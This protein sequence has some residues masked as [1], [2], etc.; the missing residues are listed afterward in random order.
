MLQS[1][2]AFIFYF[3]LK[4]KVMI[5]KLARATYT[6]TTVGI[7]LLILRIGVGV[8][9]MHHGYGKLTHFDE[10][11]GDFMNFIGLG[12]AISLSLVIFAEFFCSLLIFI[13]LFTS[14]ATIP[15]IITMGVAVFMA[16]DAA[17]FAKG[18]LATLYLFVYVALMFAGPGKYSLDAVIARQLGVKNVA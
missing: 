14:L 4:V 6:E 11:K 7:S 17:I 13:G 16:H 2:I 15:L 18:E 9:M 8:L 10:Y 3:Q 12:P 1:G 5:H